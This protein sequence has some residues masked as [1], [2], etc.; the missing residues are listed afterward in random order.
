M[1][2]FVRQY[3]YDLYMNRI[4]TKITSLSFTDMWDVIIL[5]G[6]HSLPSFET[7]EDLRIRIHG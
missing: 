5:T 7:F 6:R 2:N 1:R 3:K 4:N